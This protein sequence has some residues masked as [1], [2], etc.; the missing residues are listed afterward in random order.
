M[1][2]CHEITN[3]KLLHIKS[4]CEYLMACSNK[5]KKGTLS[6]EFLNE[7]DLVVKISASL[8]KRRFDNILDFDDYKHYGFIGLLEAK[9]KYSS[10]KGASFDTYATYRIRGAIL[11][12][13][14][15]HS[16][17]MQLYAYKSRIEKDRL[18]SL[19]IPSTIDQGSLFDSFIDLTSNLA[20]AEFLDDMSELDMFSDPESEAYYK[21]QVSSD[22][23][24]GVEQL[25]G[26]EKLVITYH[27]FGSLGF[28]E[29]GDILSLTKGRIS[30][31]HRS[32]LDKLRVTLE[33]SSHYSAEI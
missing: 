30:Q 6:S 13:I 3:G 2:Y 14:V 17:K 22:L 29:I 26:N 5:E 16:E 25:K 23:L 9:N 20:I 33:G 31:L 24:L 18:K 8:Y 7:E 11:N 12:G 19:E 28:Q 21:S 4:H 1:V 10:C 32:S 27:Y 15:K